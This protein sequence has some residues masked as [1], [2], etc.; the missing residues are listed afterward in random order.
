LGYNLRV[1]NPAVAIRPA[2]RGDLPAILVLFAD[3]ELHGAQSAH[4][5]LSDAQYAA[6]DAIEADPNNQVYVAERAGELVG[7]FQLT[8]IRQLSYGGCL[9]AQVESVYVAASARSHGVGALMMGFAR[10]QAEQRGAF[11]LQLTSNLKRERAHRFYERL[12][13]QATHKGMKL[14]L[15]QHA[16]SERKAH[17]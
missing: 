11:R 4:V 17:S 1:D 12:G 13:F 5:T 16:A 7:T 8:F 9:V 2:K 3:D 6:F 15:Q 14:Q 10:A